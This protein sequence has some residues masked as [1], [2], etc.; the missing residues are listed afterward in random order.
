[1]KI[2][3][4]KTYQCEKCKKFFRVKYSYYL[5]INYKCPYKNIIK[6]E[7]QQKQQN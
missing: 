5:H 2:N 4:K 1:M 7:Q 3:K 6:L